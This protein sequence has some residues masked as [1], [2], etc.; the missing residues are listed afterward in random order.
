MTNTNRNVTYSN[1]LFDSC[2]MCHF[3]FILLHLHVGLIVFRSVNLFCF[4]ILCKKC[5]YAN[6]VKKKCNIV[7][8]GSARGQKTAGDRSDR[9]GGQGRQAKNE[10]LIRKVLIWQTH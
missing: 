3:F 2:K 5:V 1:F 8:A 4:A 6:N 7:F 9:G 10:A